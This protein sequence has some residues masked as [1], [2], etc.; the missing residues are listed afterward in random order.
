MMWIASARSNLIFLFL[1]AIYC[2][3]NTISLPYHPP[4]THIDYHPLISYLRLHFGS[5][6]KTEF[7][8]KSLK[9][10]DIFAIFFQPK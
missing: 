9:F 8:K 10:I 1:I 6:K 7:I 2:I 4:H 3:Y 5:K